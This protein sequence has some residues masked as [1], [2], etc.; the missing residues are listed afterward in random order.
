VTPATPERRG[1]VRKLADD[2]ITNGILSVRGH[3]DGTVDVTDERSGRTY[4]GLHRF[5]DVADRGDEYNF[6]PVE[7]DAPI[8][9]D[10]P[11]EVRVV[12]AGPVVAELEIALV[13]R[14]PRH[15]SEDRRR[16]VGHVGIPIRTRIRLVHG[17]D[18]V[19]F[20]TTIE[21]RARDHRLRVR[22]PIPDAS[23]LTP[24][25]AE[26]HFDVVRRTAW[27][28][29]RGG[30]WTEPPAY[31]SHTSGATAAA[32][33]AVIGR[34]LPEY[35]AVPVRGGLE[36]AL[37]LLRCVGWLSR[38]DLATRAGGAGPTLPTPGAQCEGRWTF[39]YAV[40]PGADQLSDADLLRA[41]A[42]Y[43]TAPAL[44][45]ERAATIDPP[46]P[47]VTV[48][49]DVVVTALK[50]AEDGRGAI[51]RFVNTGDA[52][53]AAAIGASF[54]ATPVRLDETELPVLPSETLRPREIR[55][56]RL[57]GA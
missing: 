32:D 2:T 21:N 10:Q 9:V 24:V 26:G 53:V 8:G 38:D 54:E 33:L 44:G 48:E 30:G 35:E 31:T 37:T 45:P 13:L 57:T 4:P 55:T 51:L 29:W 34:G 27:P 23:D 47:I 50:P 36:L 7:F 28:V 15:L 40:V 52:G 41:S 20:T 12:A 49:G 6:C 5:E 42:D 11:A 46:E 1:S 19:E 3:P 17:I 25:R 14:L 39:E 22:F 43:R 56:I 16:R 18:R